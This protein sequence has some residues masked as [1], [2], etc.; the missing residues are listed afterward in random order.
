MVE[1]T[2]EV[3]KLNSKTASQKIKSFQ[4]SKKIVDI[5]IPV[6]LMEKGKYLVVTI[7]AS[8]VKEMTEK[9]YEL[10]PA[11][12]VDFVNNWI[13]DNIHQA[14]DEYVE[15]GKK[16]FTVGAAAPKLAAVATK[17]QPEKAAPEKKPESVTAETMVPKPV[18]PAPAFKMP[19]GIEEKKVSGKKTTLAGEKETK[20]KKTKTE[21]I[22]AISEGVEKNEK[23]KVKFLSVYLDLS[24]KGV[25]ELAGV[26][27]DIKFN[28]TEKEKGLSGNALKKVVD[29]LAKKVMDELKKRGY[30]A[31]YIVS[32]AYTFHLEREIK[33]QIKNKITK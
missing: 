28:V 7:P 4:K 13:K 20:K 26:S 21:K 19:E 32:A 6:P 10:P 18:K 31:D 22:G 33:S 16:K 23:A 8:A 29:D 24:N 5:V 15:N 9:A 27:L 11:K 3:Q 17:V 30:R 2:A 14:I 12:R 1:I 25:D